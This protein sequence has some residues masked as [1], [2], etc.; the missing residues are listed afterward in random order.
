MLALSEMKWDLV[1]LGRCLRWDV[2]PDEN[3]GKNAS[4]GQS[5]GLYRRHSAHA[6]NQLAPQWLMGVLVKP[7]CTPQNMAAV[8]LQVRGLEMPA[9]AVCKH[10]REGCGPFTSCIVDFADGGEPLFNGDC[11]NCRWGGDAR[12]GFRKLSGSLDY[13]I[14]Y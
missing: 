10:C 12:C 8:S 1:K 13:I 5:A 9:N 14:R 3:L 4:S 6:G 11:G 2:L 7:I